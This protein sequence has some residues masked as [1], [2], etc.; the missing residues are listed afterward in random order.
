MLLRMNDAVVVVDAVAGLGESQTKGVSLT[1]PT[2]EPPG[3]FGSVRG[4]SFHSNEP[5]VEQ[6][7][8]SSAE[9]VIDMDDETPTTATT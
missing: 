8:A 4:Y 3:F 5:T 6:T 7:M 9:K 2:E 1:L